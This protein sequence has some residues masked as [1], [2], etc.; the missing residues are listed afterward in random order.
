MV[1]KTCTFIISHLNGLLLSEVKF[2]SIPIIT[3]VIAIKVT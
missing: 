2:K 1:N 3:L